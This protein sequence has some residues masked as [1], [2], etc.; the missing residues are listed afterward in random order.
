MLGAVHIDYPFQEGIAPS[1]PYL[2]R[3]H[4]PLQIPHLD[5]LVGEGVDNKANFGSPVRKAALWEE[6]TT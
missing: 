1:N 3:G 6:R 2:Q 5:I 4:A